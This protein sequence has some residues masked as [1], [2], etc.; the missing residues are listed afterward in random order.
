MFSSIRVRLTLWYM[1]VFGVL[2][3]AF[4]L[5]VYLVLSRNLYSRLDTSLANSVRTVASSF[6]S[7]M[8]ESGGNAAE[9]AAEALNTLELSGADVAIYAG[10]RLLA[11]NEAARKT[12]I[13]FN[14]DSIS[15]QAS[16]QPFLQTVPGFGEEG[17]RRIVLPLGPPEPSHRSGLQSED[18]HYYVVITEPL[19]DLEEQLE[20]IRRIF[21][22]G[23][24]ATLL[25]AGFGG[26]LLARKSLAPVVA[27]SNQAAQIGARNLHERL[28]VRNA[29]DELGRLASVFNELLSRLDHSFEAMKAFVADASHELRTPI[30]IIRGEAEVALL[31]AR[32]SAEYKAA[33]VTIQDEAKQLS[34][35]VD[36]L[37]ALAR[38]DAGERPLKVDE[39]YLND[40]VE[41]CCRTAQVLAAQK[42]LSLEMRPAADLPFRGDEDLLRRMIFNLLDNA[43]KYT[44]SGGAVTVNLGE[45]NGIVELTVSDTGIGIPAEAAPQIF[46]RFFRVA[47]ARSRADGG[48]G[49]GLAIARWA[50]EAH[51]GSITVASRPGEGSTFTVS[52]RS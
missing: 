2:L 29:A 25:A 27:M 52:L 17:G 41:E 4:S 5:A 22:F 46:E 31:Q 13:P 48:T 38:A 18:E 40:L 34:R 33:L 9:G 23:L 12:F 51:N 26:L 10:D 11:S 21:Y 45:R 19:H 8:N 50:A 6:R 32:D 3:S 1:L 44:P 15:P 35:L 30:S 43:I 28:R 24:P 36:D 14:P 16:G 7:E 37:L 20:A 47:K 39:F 42:S 49:L